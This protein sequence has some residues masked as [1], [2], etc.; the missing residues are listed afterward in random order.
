MPEQTETETP[1]QNTEETESSA[2]PEIDFP[3]AQKLLNLHPPFTVLPQNAQ[4]TLDF[5]QL[6]QVQTI[7][8][9]KNNCTEI[10]QGELIEIDCDEVV[11]GVR[12]DFIHNGS[13]GIK[14]VFL[15]ITTSEFDDKQEFVKVKYEVQYHWQEGFDTF[16]KR[17][18]SGRPGYLDGQPI[19]LG[20]LV[21]NTSS[22][23]EMKAIVACWVPSKRIAGGY[24]KD[25][26]WKY[27]SVALNSQ[28]YKL[29]ERR[30]VVICTFK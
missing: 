4:S 17:K 1:S 2:P 16:E 11:T 28:Y 10:A 15:M 27:R 20:Q 24:L 14:S 9:R 12:F 6:I 3:D 13:E 18:R 21:T 19:I 8:C 23:G 5:Q 22:K 29:E 7:L 30:H 26:I 25:I